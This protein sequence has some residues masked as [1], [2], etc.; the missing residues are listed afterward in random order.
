MNKLW[1]VLLASLCSMRAFGQEATSSSN[2]G[3]NEIP[4]RVKLYSSGPDTKLPVL[5]IPQRALPGDI[6]CQK[7]L[8]G[9]VSF[10]LIVDSIGRPRNLMFERPDGSVLDEVAISVAESDRFQPGVAKGVP[11]AFS[12]HLEMHLQGC[13]LQ[14]KDANGNERTQVQLRSWPEQK[15][16]VDTQAGAEATLALFPNSNKMIRSVKEVAGSVTPPQ[17]IFQP[18][19]G[20]SEEARHKKITGDCLL[21]LVVDEHGMP[22]QIRVMQGLE[23]GLDVKAIQ[24]VQRYRFKPAMQEGEPVSMLVQVDVRFRLY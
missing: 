1:I 12:F 24:A 19:A 21:E 7:K 20:Y 23:P 22:Q 15:F 14:S 13:V 11:A 3:S 17:T 6:K 2:E 8:S 9:K 16:S 4:E 18:D 10:S 5:I